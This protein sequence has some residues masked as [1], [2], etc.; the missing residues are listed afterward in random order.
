MADLSEQIRTN[1]AAPRRM[2]VDGNTAEQ[3]SL[4]EQIE[5]DQYLRQRDA[6]R[7]SKLPIRL[8]KIQPGGTT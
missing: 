7:G 8:A 5:A 1:A 3:H 4:R 2:T 6:G